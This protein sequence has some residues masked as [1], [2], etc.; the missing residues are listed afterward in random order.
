MPA[1][2]ALAVIVCP[3]MTRTNRLP[4]RPWQF[5]RGYQNISC[6]IRFCVVLSMNNCAVI[7][8]AYTSITSQPLNNL[9]SQDLNDG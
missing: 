1:T 6:S 3:R 4:A 9:N 7:N 5:F 8:R 2:S